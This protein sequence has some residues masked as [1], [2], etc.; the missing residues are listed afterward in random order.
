MVDS[1][2]VSPD[3]IGTDG[4]LISIVPGEIEKQSQSKQSWGFDSVVVA[5]SLNLLLFGKFGRWKL[6][7]VGSAHI[8]R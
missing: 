2:T 4:R 6:K 5:G 7:A 1:P 3:I 8:D